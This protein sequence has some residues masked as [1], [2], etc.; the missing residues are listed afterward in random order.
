MPRSSKPSH[1]EPHVAHVAR[2]T[3]YGAAGSVEVVADAC[4]PPQPIGL[5]ISTNELDEDGEKYGMA[6]NMSPNE[7]RAL[8]ELLSE[9]AD[10]AQGLEPGGYQP[11]KRVP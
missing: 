11:G 2:L 6:T 5:S 4:D 3:L 1:E 7:A 9:A 8:A 10:L